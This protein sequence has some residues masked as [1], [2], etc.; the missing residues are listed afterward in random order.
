MLAERTAM[1]I[2]AQC[3]HL[4]MMLD[5]ASCDTTISKKTQ[6]SVHLAPTHKAAMQQL[7]RSMGIPRARMHRCHCIFHGVA[8]LLQ[9][10]GGAG[11]LLRCVVKH[12]HRPAVVT[13]TTDA[14]SLQD[15]P[16]PSS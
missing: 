10:C 12:P 15:T 1:K 8:V 4:L 11:L 7:Q 6:R 2:L 5:R 3:R 9:G 13:C 14:G 16:A